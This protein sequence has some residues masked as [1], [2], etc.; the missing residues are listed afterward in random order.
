MF[1]NDNCRIKIIDDEIRKT[2]TTAYP[3]EKF[4]YNIEIY[5]GSKMLHYFAESSRERISKIKGMIPRENNALIVVNMDGRVWKQPPGLN[6]NDY[7]LK[8]L[9]FEEQQSY[10]DIKD[11]LRIKK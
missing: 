9:I 11:L 10:N 3:A 1:L 8:A 5:S 6:Y 7:K 2:L 4:Y